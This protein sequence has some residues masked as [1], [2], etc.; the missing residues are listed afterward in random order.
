M[1][2]EDILNIF[3]YDDESSVFVGLG[4]RGKNDTRTISDKE[5]G[6]ARSKTASGGE[7]RYANGYKYCSMLGSYA[8]YSCI[9]ITVF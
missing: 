3:Y 2:I 8:R 7:G 1:C 6:Q 4:G 9:Q 5:R